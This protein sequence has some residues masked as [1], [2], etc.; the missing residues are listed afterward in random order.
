MTQPTKDFDVIFF[1]TIGNAFTRESLK[2]HPSG[3]AEIAIVKYA[4]WLAEQGYSVLVLN[5]VAGLYEDGGVTYTNNG[6][7]N[8]S[9]RALVISRY[10]RIPSIRA[11]KTV[12]W[13]VDADAACHAHQRELLES[14]KAELIAISP[15]HASLFPRHW[16]IRL[17]PSAFPDRIYEQSTKYRDPNKFV[18]ASA[19]LKGLDA[20]LRMW[21]LIKSRH[22][23][24]KD[25]KL[26]VTTPGY[27][28]P[29]LD[30]IA[31]TTDVVWRG[32]LSSD[33][34]EEELRSAAGM[35][36]VNTFG[37]TFCMAAA[38]AEAV[39]C[40]P[41]ILLAGDQGAI[42]WTLR[43]S[44]VT[45]NAEAFEAN[46][47]NA[48][49]T[50]P[51][52]TKPYPF[53]MSKIMPMWLDVLGLKPMQVHITARRKTCLLMIVSEKTTFESLKRCIDS[54]A[55]I[56]DCGCIVV[57]PSSKV[58]GLVS[59]AFGAKPVEI[60]EEQW[61]DFGHNRSKCIEHARGMAD[62]NLMMDADDSLEFEPWFE[63]PY[64]HHDSYDILIRD[65][66]ME[67]WRPHFFKNA[68]DYYYE[69]AMHEH[70]AKRTPQGFAPRLHGVS[71][72][73]NTAGS[74]EVRH[75]KAIESLSKKEDSRSVFYLAQELKDSGRIAEAIEVY[76]RRAGMRDG[77]DEEVFF[78]LLSVG[79]MH[80]RLESPALMVESAFCRAY[81]SRPG[82]GPEAL[83]DLAWFFLNRKDWLKAYFYAKKG[84][85]TPYPDKDVLFIDRD[86]Y[87]WKM[88]DAA[89]I[90]A[91][92]MGNHREAKELGE[93]LLESGSLPISQ[94]QR[95]ET[96]LN[97]SLVSLHLP[98][99]NEYAAPAIDPKRAKAFAGFLSRLTELDLPKEA[100]EHWT[101]RCRS[102][103][104]SA[105]TKPL[106]DFLVWSDDVDIHEYNVSFRS[107]WEELKSD[108]QWSRWEALSRKTKERHHDLSIDGGSSPINVQHAYHLK[109]YEEWTGDRFLDGVDTVVE[110]GGG[111]GNFA[112]ML[113]LDGFKGRHIII[114]LPHVREIQRLF[115]ELTGSVCLH[116]ESDSVEFDSGLELWTEDELGR[117][118]RASGRIAFI[119][120]WSLSETPLTFR[121]KLF[122]QLHKHCVKYLIASQWTYNWFGIDNPSYFEQFQ[123]DAGGD[124]IVRPVPHHGSENYL[125]G[126]KR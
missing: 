120:T 42:P 77:F 80:V 50:E 100:S 116:P 60:F 122:P 90:A 104:E 9:C 79:K 75:D 15:W 81:E 38:L 113:R 54:V 87:E 3:A 46:F 12:I 45:N 114:D 112:R 94:R 95:I 49:G 51:P 99:R 63:M 39:G 48:F 107:W 76:E 53:R 58:R 40:R 103:V 85:G 125:F 124:W 57:D 69:G 65:V 72:K 118:L 16:P 22:P 36:Y 71:Y 29:D 55:S 117:D 52:V 13:S 92:W 82:R 14:K 109:T 67:Y 10:S 111:Y 28:R 101:G 35:F 31:K 56:V 102:M 106:V 91:A 7:E 26:Y 34:V 32:E 97:F 83:H 41:H 33:L 59:K 47:V 115:A 78:S 110:V 4:H 70:L 121:E 123:K 126:V 37:E 62:Y 21:S 61:V 96:N 30:Q 17:I 6:Y 27:D 84:L 20:T 23:K 86:I 25:A 2:T 8:Y 44:L 119:A 5:G 64:L 66:R 11:D 18:F 93:Q 24:I 89:A 68:S 98:T 105:V 43:S 88:Q 108:K 19:A 1:D 73:R 74:D